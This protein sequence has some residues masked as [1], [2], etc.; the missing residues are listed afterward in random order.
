METSGCTPAEEYLGPAFSDVLLAVNEADTED[1]AHPNL[2][3][4]Y[5]KDIYAGLRQLE[6]EQAIR[7]K[8]P[9]GCE[10]TGNT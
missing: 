1:G 10:V 3:S 5:V 6:E 8:Y 9:L 7:P 2:G 4:E